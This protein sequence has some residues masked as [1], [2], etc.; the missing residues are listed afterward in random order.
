VSDDEPTVL[1]PRAAAAGV[2]EPDARAGDT[3]AER[4][5][6]RLE[7]WASD[8]AQRVIVVNGPAALAGALVGVFAAQ[9]GERFRLVR[10]ASPS[11]DP[12]A[13]SRRILDSL[14]ELDDERPRAA[15]VRLIQEAGAPPILLLIE[16]AQRLSPR[17]EMWLFDLVRRSGGALRVLLAL[18]DPKPANELAAAYH[19]RT[20]VVPIDEP[21]PRAAAQPDVGRVARERAAIAQARREERESLESTSVEA[22]AEAPTV[23]TSPLPGAARPRPRAPSPAARKPGPPPELTRRDDT[24]RWLLLPAALAACFV[25]GFVTSELLQVLRGGREVARATA[26]IASTAP[27]AGEAEPPAVASP[28]P[29]AAPAQAKAADSPL[30]MPPRASQPPAEPPA[31]SSSP[32][33]VAS[34]GQAASPSSAAPAPPS[35]PESAAAPVP[36]PA[37]EAPPTA[38]VEPDAEEPQAPPK[39]PERR[40]AR[41]PARPSTPRGVTVGV[42]AEPGTQIAI[43]GRALGAAPVDEVELA[44][45][46]H[47]LVATLPD[48]RVV[49]RV[50][51]V[52][53]DSRYDIHLR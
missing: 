14:G 30:T 2:E 6:E 45:G 17:T 46:P 39:A 13:L 18:A 9:C 27:R 51:D 3:G 23:A 52:P 26:P 22:V 53:Q 7:R 8:P 43:D 5:L 33:A 38:E 50:V 34:R 29:S 32:P 31:V 25:A 37:A 10:L 20:E 48:G 28:P 41:A 49:D 15:L 42:S 44:S 24:L 40:H 36:S 12:D 35:P 16:E 1:D 4:A 11:L 19:G 47:R 21:A